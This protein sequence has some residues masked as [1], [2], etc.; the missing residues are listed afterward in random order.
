[1]GL[2]LRDPATAKQHAES[3]AKAKFAE[4]RDPASCA[5]FYAALGKKKL[6]QASHTK[7]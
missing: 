6:L 7:P 4:T 5:L 1:M 2:W 3:L